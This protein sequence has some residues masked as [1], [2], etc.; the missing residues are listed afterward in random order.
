[1]PRDYQKEAADRNLYHG[2]PLA[3]MMGVDE[4]TFTRSDGW[5]HSWCYKCG[6]YATTRP[7]ESLMENGD[8]RL[9][10]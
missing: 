9:E 7:D 10:Q 4:E 1:M 2:V 3:K 6:C 5:I 8:W